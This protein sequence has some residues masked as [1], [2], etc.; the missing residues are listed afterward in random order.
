M[1]CYR[2]GQPEAVQAVLEQFPVSRMLSF[3]EEI[4]IRPAERQGYY[5]PYTNAAAD[6]RDCLE[7]ELR[8]LGVRTLL[9]YRV[10]GIGK[11][12]GQFRIRL[13]KRESGTLGSK[14][15]P[16]VSDAN[17]K[18]DEKNGGSDAGRKDENADGEWMVCASACILATGGQA[19][20]K[21]GSD[22]FGYRLAKD[23]G[24]HLIPVAPAL[25]D[26]RCNEKF[27]HRLKGIRV[28]AEVRLFVDGRLAARDLGEVQ[29]TER[30]I[31]G[32]PVFNVSRYA[33]K[34]LAGNEVTAELDFLPELS[35]G[36]AVDELK[37]RL[38]NYGWGKTVS[39]AFRGLLHQRLA[40]V[41]LGYA[42]IDAAADAAKLDGRQVKQLA[43]A[44]K[45]FS[46]SVAGAG[47]FDKAQ[48]TAG[49]V[50]LSE[51]DPKTLESAHCKGLYLC[52]ELLDVDGICGGYN[53]SWAWASGYV[54]GTAV[55]RLV[56]T[57]A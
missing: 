31:S 50:P 1:D 34:A 6:V 30:G 57:S 38:W 53:L 17:G 16:A 20:P 44:C 15:H 11:E 8:R 5:Y 24:H 9:G 47:G 27:F 26:L 45:A 29:L 56:H 10:C 52:G 3:F 41:L 48:T 28:A 32:I 19:F 39:E 21:S 55:G 23:F 18:S 7:M 40:E 2:S 33:T 49:G 46:V 51:V 14:G 4:G 54:C 35:V 42:K 25:V 37:Q 12:D 36:E 43:E 22:G 13:R